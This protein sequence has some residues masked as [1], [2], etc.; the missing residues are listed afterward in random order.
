MTRTLSAA[1]VLA[2]VAIPA[3]A[4]NSLDVN[5]NAAMNSTN[6][7]LEV[8]FDGSV[9]NAYVQDDTPASETVYRASFWLDP[10]TVTMN[11]FSRFPVL[12]LRDGGNIVRLQLQNRTD[13]NTYRMR[14]QIR[15]SA[16][17]FVP[18]QDPGTG[19]RFLPIG[20]QPVEVTIQARFASAG[21]AL[22][23]LQVDGGVEYIRDGF[24]NA[25]Q[26]TVN[27]VRFGGTRGIEANFNGSI[28]LD[29]FASFRTLN[30]I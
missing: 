10:N 7:G 5:A 13:L 22:L 1:V 9:N 6:F 14:A 21:Q 8:L 28:Y 24:G 20:D 26:G 18:A 3:T 4:D 15:N 16:G 17:T 11:N 30:A 19:A 27:S 25:N 12:L 2:M 29:E 23:T